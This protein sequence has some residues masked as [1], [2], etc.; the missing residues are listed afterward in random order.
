MFGAMLYPYLVNPVAL[1]AC[2]QQ[3]S[4][5]RPSNFGAVWVLTAVSLLGGGIFAPA[6]ASHESSRI[7]AAASKP[8][9]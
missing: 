1:A 2:F 7:A 8:P 6:R 4:S 9:I 3:A 5:S